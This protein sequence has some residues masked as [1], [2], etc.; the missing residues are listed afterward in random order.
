MEG[1]V[2]SCRAVSGHNRGP[3]HREDGSA[4]HS[5]GWNRT[6][7]R[8]SLRAHREAQF[9]RAVSLAI[10]FVCTPCT[11]S[12][13]FIDSPMFGRSVSSLDVVVQAD[14]PRQLPMM[15]KQHSALLML[16]SVGERLMANLSIL[17][18]R[19]STRP[20]HLGLSLV[21][22]NSVGRTE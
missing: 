19:P 6:R 1:G 13:L 15:N 2:R 14:R 7:E 4:P 16:A 18:V 10:P 22:H 17:K 11:V 3:V 12:S 5:Q 21:F 8:R 9:H 20:T